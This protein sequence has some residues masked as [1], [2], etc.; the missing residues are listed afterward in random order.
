MSK[1]RFTIK[2]L[3]EWSDERIIY[4]ILN[5]RFKESVSFGPFSQRLEKIRNNYQDYYL[6]NV[7]FG[8]SVGYGIL[9]GEQS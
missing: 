9:K 2:E 6:S 7:H 5:D 4:T 3:N 1:H 8:D